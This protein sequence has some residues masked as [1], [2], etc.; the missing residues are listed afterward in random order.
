MTFRKCPFPGMLPVK[1]IWPQ[2]VFKNATIDL[3]VSP[4]RY[5]GMFLFVCTVFH[6]QRFK[7]A[8][9]KAS[10]AKAKLRPKT[11]LCRH[12]QGAAILH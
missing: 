2:T 5:V 6:R 12:I 11:L 10:K 3:P 9:A 1:T 7:D 4:G 8:E